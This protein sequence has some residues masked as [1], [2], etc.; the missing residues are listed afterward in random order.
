VSRCPHAWHAAV[1]ASGVVVSWPW[2]EDD[3]WGCAVDDGSTRQAG[4]AKAQ[5]SGA[6][7]GYPIRSHPGAAVFERGTRPP[8]SRRAT[9]PTSATCVA[10]DLAAMRR[11]LP[12]QLKLPLRTPRRQHD[13]PAPPDGSTHHQPSRVATAAAA[14]SCVAPPGS[15]IRTRAGQIRA[16]LCSTWRVGG[17]CTPRL[18]AHP[19]A[20]RVPRPRGRLLFFSSSQEKILRHAPALRKG[21]FGTADTRSLRILSTVRCGA[22]I[23]IMRP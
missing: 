2:G 3:D 20:R 19:H 10:A 18:A 14:A 8:E 7:A 13:L 21:S 22:S 1:R 17:P 5:S 4:Q 11:P 12:L 16:G 9:T 6:V 15:G 23:S